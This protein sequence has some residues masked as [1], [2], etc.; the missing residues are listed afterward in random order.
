MCAHY[1]SP[2]EHDIRAY[3]E[4]YKGNPLAAF[5]GDN[6]PTDL[7]PFIRVDRES[8]E[9]ELGLGRFGLVPY[10]TKPEDL[11]KAGRGTYNARTETVHEKPSFKTAWKYRNWCVIPAQAIYEPCYETGKAVPWR[12]QRTDG[13]LMAIAGIRWT[14]VNRATDQSVES[15]SMLT[16]NADDHPLMRRFHKPGDEKRMVVLLD[17]DQHDAWLNATTDEART[18]FCQFRADRLHAEAASGIGSEL[19]LPAK[20]VSD[21]PR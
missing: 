20:T 6:Y 19:S 10:W 2:Q 15:F 12:I 3:F 16:I 1:E 14:W 13:K 18:F 9:R 8:G 5:K 11:R 7:A 21:T 17:D 4:L